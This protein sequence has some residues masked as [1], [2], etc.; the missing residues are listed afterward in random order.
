MK[1]HLLETLDARDASA[2]ASSAPST[3]SRRYFHVGSDSVT[4][5]A[6]FRKGYATK[7]Y[8]LNEVAK[9]DRGTPRLQRD[10]WRFV[11]IAGSKNVVADQ[12]SRLAVG[13]PA[14]VWDKAAIA[15][16]LR[17]LLGE[18]ASSPV[19]RSGGGSGELAG[20]PQTTA[21]LAHS[22]LAVATNP[23]TTATT[24]TPT[25]TS[26]QKPHHQQTRQMNYNSQSNSSC[27][28][29]LSS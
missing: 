13:A 11:H 27:S 5:V 10:Q 1:R 4:A 22:S 16:S 24:T 23:Q 6:L 9:E 3:P 26:E 28:P 12:L 25:A 20:Q 21:S 8:F 2:S 17:R 7:S 18:T 14:V 15:E 19:D 29:S